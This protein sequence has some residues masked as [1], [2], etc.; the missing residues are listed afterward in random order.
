MVMTG[1]QLH[2][3]ANVLPPRKSV[4]K[5]Y[6]EVQDKVIVHGDW[7]YTVQVNPRV[8]PWIRE[9]SEDLWYNHLT[10]SHYKVLDTF[11]IHEKLYTFLVLRWS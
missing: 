9:Q 8:S 1:T 2:G 5:G 10:P 6:F 3:Q 4:I 11:D 7:W